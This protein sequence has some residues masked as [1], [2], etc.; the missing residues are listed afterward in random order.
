MHQDLEMDCLVD[1][2]KFAVSIPGSTGR[3]N[4]D[5]YF[6][7]PQAS[8]VVNVELDAIQL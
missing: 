2:S 4:I 1:D 5:L 3:E 8:G 6:Q 7:L